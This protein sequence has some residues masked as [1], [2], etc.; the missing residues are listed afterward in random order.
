MRF[1]LTLCHIKLVNIFQQNTVKNYL[2]NL[3]E[4]Y[5]S[6]FINTFKIS[7]QE[8]IIYLERLGW[9]FLLDLN[10]KYLSII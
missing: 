7:S 1:F 5:K 4:E 8:F 10:N 2:T 6:E 3:F 9:C